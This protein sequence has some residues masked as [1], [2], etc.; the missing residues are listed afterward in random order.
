MDILN[1]L[2]EGAQ[3]GA[4]DQIARKF[5]LDGA[6]TT[7]VIGQ[8]VPALAGGLQK[9]T[10]SADGLA[11]LVKALQGGGHQRYLDEPEALADSG[12]IDDGNGILGHLLGSKDVSRQVASQA[13]SNTG[14]DAGII[15]KMLPLVATL[16][17]GSLSKQTN[18]GSQLQ[19]ETG[20][21]LLGGLLGGGEGGGLDD[22][23]GLAGKLLK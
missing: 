17:M 22:L 11:G 16:V 19:E 8:L 1:V 23:I 15:K 3:G 21:G 7:D 10:Q 18:A 14:I 2:L 9:N 4:T 6:Q 5:G 13:A 12:A 20:G